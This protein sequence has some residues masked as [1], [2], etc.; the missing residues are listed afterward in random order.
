MLWQINRGVTPISKDKSIS[1]NELTYILLNSG[2]VR[3]ELEETYFQYSSCSGWFGFRAADYAM[4]LA[5]SFGG[6]C[7]CHGLNQNLR[8]AGDYF[9]FISCSSVE[10]P[11]LG[12]NSIYLCK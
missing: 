6:P 4:K 8:P 3:N 7:V 5:V 10:V 11:N 1:R 2:I 12:V 9:N